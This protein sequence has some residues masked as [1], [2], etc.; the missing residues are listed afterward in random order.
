[1]SVV[2]LLASVTTGLEAVL[3]SRGLA[4][5]GPPFRCR[6]A[7]GSPGLAPLVE[8]PEERSLFGD[9]FLKTKKKKTRRL[10]SY[11]IG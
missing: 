9:S 4:W 8:D 11:L 6:A 2:G 7:A 3:S 10:S 1:M 5:C